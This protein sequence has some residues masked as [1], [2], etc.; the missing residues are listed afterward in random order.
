MDYLSNA[1]IKDWVKEKKLETFKQSLE[2]PKCG[3]D[4]KSNGVTLTS[5]LLGTLTN[6]AAANIV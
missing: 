3:G 5:N 6:V 4:L 2:C 1:E